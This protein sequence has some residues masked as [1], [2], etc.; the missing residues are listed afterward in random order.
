MAFL[1]KIF[2][3]VAGKWRVGAGSALLAPLRLTSVGLQLGRI[4][5]PAERRPPDRLP[6]RA[7]ALLRLQ[8]CCP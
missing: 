5:A 3:R 6:L 8:H 4:G 1:G 2:S 7:I